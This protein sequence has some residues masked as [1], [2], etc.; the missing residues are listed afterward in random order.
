VNRTADHK[1]DRALESGARWFQRDTG[2][3]LGIV[4]LDRLP[5]GKTI[6][7]AS[8]ALFTDLKLGRKSDGK[9][10]LFV[11]DEKDRLFKIEVSYDLE[12]VFP[13]VL[14]K[15]LE[16]GARTFMLSSSPY[17][18]RD[19][20]IELAVTMKLRYLE[21]RKNGT[22]ADV[23]APE[24]GKRYVGGYLHGGAGMVGRGYASTVANVER[25]LNALPK[26]LEESMQ[27]GRTPQETLE[28][29][30]RSLEMGI[31]APNVPLL[32]EAS[33]YFR[34]DKPH[35][36][37]YLRRI[38][39][40]IA[41]SQAPRILRQGDLAAATFGVRD[42]VLPIFMRRDPEGLW[43]VDEPKVWAAYHLFQDGSHNLKYDGMAFEFAAL[44]W[45]TGQ[46]RT[47]LFGSNAVPPA[48]VPLPARLKE[49]LQQ[50]EARVQAEP[51]NVAAWIALADLL[52]FE[53]FWLQP[54]EAVYE[55]IVTLAPDRMD[56]HWR[57][58]DIYEMTSDVDGQNRLWCTIL[59]RDPN[60]P[61]AAHWY[62]HFRK[63][64]YETDPDT[65]VCRD[66]AGRRL[67]G[68]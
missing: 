8:D 58:L 45:P 18:R 16:E 11:W 36:P 1:H 39:E 32:T 41:K 42:P 3:N 55:R 27:P 21:F 35:A 6:E 49:R 47:A 51:A 25:E 60:H 13:D 54:S 22:L 52:H 67:D 46:K 20:L 31:G 38:R 19:F 23:T 9:A 15:R 29:Y 34:M 63:S 24:A 28:R 50:A 33:R 56:M 7:T 26:E 10:L 14:C 5:P 65:D 4:L 44:P 37:G 59:R 48:L 40:Y 61:I 66:K 43:Y 2:I 17:A 57:L 53:I 12:Q 64:F 68:R 30:L 62:Q